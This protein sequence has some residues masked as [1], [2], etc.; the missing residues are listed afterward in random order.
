M[1]SDALVAVV[2]V[3]AAAGAMIVGLAVLSLIAGRSRPESPDQPVPLTAGL[4]PS[5]AEGVARKQLPV[6]AE[7]LSAHA[8]SAAAQAVRAQAAVAAA[9]TALTSAEA[10]RSRA[11][12]EYDSARGAYDALLRTAADRSDPDREARERDVSRAALAAYRRG[13]L[14]VEALRSVFGRPDPGPVREEQE[15]VADRLALAERQARRAFQQAVAAARVAREELHVV[16]VAEA[17][18]RHEAAEAALEAQDAVLA[19]RI[20]HPRSWSERARRG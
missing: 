12:A 18:V 13:E 10:V 9:R 8:D 7:E 11:E 4:P 16:E 14:S 19:A 20:A 5:V 15:R 6:L 1:N 3:A 2:A 17:A